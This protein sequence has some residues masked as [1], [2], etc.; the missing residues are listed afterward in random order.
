MHRTRFA[1]GLTASTLLLASLGMAPNASDSSRT[2]ASSRISGYPYLPDSLPPSA[3]V[4]EGILYY[5]GNRMAGNLILT[6]S[7]S[8]LVVNGFRVR[9]VPSR[10]GYLGPP[11][12]RDGIYIRDEMYEQAGSIAESAREKSLSRDE[13]LRLVRDHFLSY[14]FVKSAE[15]RGKTIDVVDIET[16]A[17]HSW[18]LSDPVDPERRRVYQRWSRQHYLDVMKECLE[19][20]LLVVGTT[21]I[22][23][24]EAAYLDEA[25]QRLRSGR[26]SSR[27]KKS[28]E[29]FRSQPELKHP[30]PLLPVTTRLYPTGP[31]PQSVVAG[32]GVV[33]IGGHRQY[34]PLLLSS[35]D[36]GLIVNGL[37]NVPTTS[38]IPQVAASHGDSIRTSLNDQAQRIA[39]DGRRRG[40]TN[41]EILRSVRDVFSKEPMVTSVEIRGHWA[42]VRYVDLP[43]EAWLELAALREPARPRE[44]QEWARSYE[45]L[46][47]KG[48]VEGGGVVLYTRRGIVY[49]SP[50]TSAETDHLIQRV[51]AGEATPDDERRL[52]LTIGREPFEELRYPIP[53][54][55]LRCP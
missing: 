2:A 45:L 13:T 54:E 38:P 1:F 34:G 46:R 39:E 12:R 26:A 16:K 24:N 25:I 30:L 53:L 49:L 19:Q 28:L 47:V 5:G 8:G 48:H 3:E 29:L 33:Y 22:P 52:M 14:K 9:S 50:Q 27:D 11:T 4:N 41:S 42:V 20:G 17:H 18:T 21:Y 15:I 6:M 35:S 40:R 23:A 43:R 31:A 37:R 10:R 55:E 32:H 36:S 7:D 51:Q 44:N